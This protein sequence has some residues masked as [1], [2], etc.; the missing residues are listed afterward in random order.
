MPRRIPA[1]FAGVN[2]HCTYLMQTILK[3]T[4]IFSPINSI[5][6][7]AGLVIDFLIKTSKSTK[8]SKHLWCMKEFYIYVLN[9]IQSEDTTGLH[10]VNQKSIQDK[11]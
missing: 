8:G 5:R 10:H 2:S 4:R 6:I 3:N 9:K 1:L 7:Q 11:S